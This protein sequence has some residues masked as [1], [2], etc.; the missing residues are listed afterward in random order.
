M[1]SFH[2][3]SGS[4]RVQYASLEQRAAGWLNTDTARTGNGQFVEG[5]R[6]LDFASYLESLVTELQSDK[7]SNAG[8]MYGCNGDVLTL[9]TG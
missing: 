8:T 5:R 3:S 1:L 2:S 6:D 7:V 4:P 9:V